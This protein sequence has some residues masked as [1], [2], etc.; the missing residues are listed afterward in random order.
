MLLSLV[1]R[2]VKAQ[3]K[4]NGT[5]CTDLL[6]FFLMRVKKEVMFAFE[7]AFEFD[8]SMVMIVLQSA[9]PW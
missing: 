2:Y 5:V 6:L 9:F 4:R 1:F 8:D 7:F 3:N